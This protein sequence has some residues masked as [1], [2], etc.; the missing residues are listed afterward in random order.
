[1]DRYTCQAVGAQNLDTVEVTEIIG[2]H[3]SGRTNNDIKAFESF[4]EITTLTFPK[5]LERF[6]PNLDS[7]LLY[8]KFNS[9][10]AADLA[11][12]PNLNYFLFQ[13]NPITSLDGNLFQ[14]SRRLQQISFYYSSIR[15]VGANLLSN[16]NELTRVD[17]RGNSCIDIEARSPQQI[18]NLKAQL[19]TQCPPL[20]TTVSPQTTTTVSTTTT[21]SGQC[22]AR[23]SINEEADALR[24]DLTNLNDEHKSVK[25]EQEKRIDNLENLAEQQAQRIVN[26]ESLVRELATS[27]CSCNS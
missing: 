16:L 2:N 24:R 10:S 6:F 5:G 14:N 8:N 15:N 27:P 7:L 23:C 26:L 19:I 20:G 17:F 18:E 25:E 1:M 21:E 11:P 22:L 4:I 9:I 13:T 12:W 3:N